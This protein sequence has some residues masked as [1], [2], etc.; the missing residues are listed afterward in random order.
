MQKKV[1]SML[2]QTALHAQSKG[3]QWYVD[4]GCS[5]HMIGDKSTF[6]TLK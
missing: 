6:L 5:S 4:N 1:E 3:N 2:V